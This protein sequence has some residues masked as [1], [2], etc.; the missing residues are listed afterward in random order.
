MQKQN[1]VLCE[2]HLQKQLLWIFFS[3]VN[4]LKVL[5]IMLYKN[6]REGSNL[7]NSTF[8]YNSCLHKG[9]DVSIHT[10]QM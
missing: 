5:K 1:T 7:S 6:R 4:N 2:L 3:F 10:G 9:D 8:Q